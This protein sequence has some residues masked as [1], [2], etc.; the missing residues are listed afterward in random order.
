MLA[1]KREIAHRITAFKNTVS[2]VFVRPHPDPLFVMG[3][4]KSGTTIIAALLGKLSDEPVSLD[5]HAESRRT[6]IPHIVQGKNTFNSLI[7][8]NRLDFSRPIIKEPA[9]T[10]LYDEVAKHYFQSKFV[11]V[12][13]D[14]RDN[15]RSL[16]NRIR[17]A[18]DRS[19]LADDDYAA[20]TQAWTHIID[21][22]WL[23]SPSDH[24]IEMMAYRWLHLVRLYEKHKDRT[25]LLKYEDFKRSKSDTIRQLATALGLEQKSDISEHVD[26][27]YQS[28]GDNSQSWEDFFGAKNLLRIEQV[29]ADTMTKFGYKV[30]SAELR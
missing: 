28:A 2:G 29:C 30:T 27:Q 11:M 4:Q 9:L 10:L 20:L 23:G 6:V 22:R 13:R 8:R 17:L 12:V 5:F 3:N 21:N 19:N 1:F 15:I 25:T 14:P 7:R 26:V 24:Y 18:G 16:L